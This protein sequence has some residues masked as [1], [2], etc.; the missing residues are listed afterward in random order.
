MGDISEAQYFKVSHLI[1]CRLRPENK[2]PTV[3]FA[4]ILILEKE[5]LILLLFSNRI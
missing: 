3:S 2:F 1:G 5:I 4:D